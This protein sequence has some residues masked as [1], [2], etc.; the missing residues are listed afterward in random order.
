[1]VIITESV[2]KRSLSFTNQRKAVIL[3]DPTGPE[4]PIL[5]HPLDSVMFFEWGRYFKKCVGTFYEKSEICERENPNLER[6]LIHLCIHF[7]H[8]FAGLS[9]S[10]V[11][12]QFS[13]QP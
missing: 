6:S 1:M 4:A 10:Q 3:R 11:W 12:P 8:H 5:P 13:C 2:H 9:H 7:S